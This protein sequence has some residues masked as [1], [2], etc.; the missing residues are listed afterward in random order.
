[1]AGEADEGKAAE[2]KEEVVAKEQMTTA[3]AAA[4][5]PAVRPATLPRTAAPET[6]PATTAERKA[7]SRRRVVP[8]SEMTAEQEKQAPGADVVATN[9]PGE[10][11]TGA[12]GS[13]R[14]GQ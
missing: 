4:A 14:Q 5:T 13:P 11:T 2:V 1:M 7:T 6:V 8:R 10:G 12:V 3:V 9:N